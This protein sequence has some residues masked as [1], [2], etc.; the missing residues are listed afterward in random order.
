MSRATEKY[1]L[2]SS[3]HGRDRRELR[4]IEKKDLQAAV[5]YGMKEQGRTVNGEFRWKYTFANVVYITDSTSRREVTSYVVPISI[6]P[7]IQSKQD[8]NWQNKLRKRIHDSPELCTS[9]TVLVLDQSASMRTCD[10]DHFKTRSDAVYGAVALDIVGNMI[11]TNQARGTDVLTL[12]E[13]KDTATIIYE[14]E[15]ITNILFNMLIERLENNSPSSHGNFFPALQKVRHVL[16]KE[17][18]AKYIAILMIFLSDGKPS[19]SSYYSM[20][21]EDAEE[22]ILNEI[23]VMS[24]MF[25]TQLTVGTIGFGQSDS[26]F[27]ILNEMA[28]TA[29][30]YGA[31]GS[32]KYSKCCPT[33]LS[34]AMTSMSSQLTLT[35]TRLE[36]SVKYIER[37]VILEKLPQH[38]LRFNASKWTIYT[39]KVERRRWIGKADNKIPMISTGA[40]G[41]AKS[42]TIFGKGAERIVFVLQELL[43]GQPVGDQ[44]AEKQSMRKT[45]K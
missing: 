30:A 18:E 14:R 37:D 21:R 25:T 40:N 5:K 17:D 41:I 36:S 11:D 19:D 28:K 29:T 22:Q 34:S 23:Q 26:S 44:L 8:M 2:I 24:E 1:T 43:D 39:D 20:N 6:Q 33:T 16:E 9:H 12:I 45:R 27:H 42:K 15:P 3:V 7:V 32:F 10:V 4:G 38:V 31:T 35:R 13:M